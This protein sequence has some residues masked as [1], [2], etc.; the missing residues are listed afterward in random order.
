LNS[1]YVWPKLLA[2]W[3]LLLAVALVI[4]VRE[5]RQGAV[6]TEDA[7][8]IGGAIALSQMAHGGAAFALICFPLL[9]L[10]LRPWPKVSLRSIVAFLLA[11]VVVAAPWW[12]YQ[13]FHD[14]PGSRLAKWHLA[15]IEEIDDRGTLEAVLDEYGALTMMGYL[16]GRFEN[17]SQQIVP[18]SGPS[19]E[20]LDDWLRRQQFFHQLLALDFLCVGFLRLNRDPYDRSDALVRKLALYASITVGVWA[21]VMFDPGSAWLHHGSYGA[22]ALL[23]FSAAAGLAE[24]PAVLR[25]PTLAAHGAM[26]VAVWVLTTHTGSLADRLPWQRT[27]AGCAALL[28]AVFA[29][30][31][32]LVPQPEPGRAV[33]PADHTPPA[34][35]GGVP[36][37]R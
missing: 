6:R 21:I 12:A 4:F 37:D 2:A 5:H 34:A 9:L 29:W 19:A 26:F 14:P 11:L 30:S 20:D 1:V 16:S 7:C 10:L 13:R 31:L 35:P 28:I 25:A 23:F 27:T 17:L 3:L 32:K 8:V 33:A 24:F 15:G 22:T 18:E 36:L